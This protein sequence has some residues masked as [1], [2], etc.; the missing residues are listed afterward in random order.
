MEV[1]MLATHMAMQRECHLYAV[2]RDF[3][4]LKQKHNAR[5]V[6]D[7]TSPT[8]DHSRSKD[9]EDWKNFMVM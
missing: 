3:S 7:P 9:N 1:S 8:L 4:Y 6:Y 5:I 2:F